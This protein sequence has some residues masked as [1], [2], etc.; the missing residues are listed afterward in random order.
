MELNLKRPLAFFDIESTGLNVSKDRIVELC[1]IKVNPN[2]TTETKTWLLNPGYPIS[3]E[4][5]KVHGISAEDVKDKPTFK[6]VAKDI[7][8]FL[9]NCDL[10]GYNSNRF[11][12]PMLVEEFLRAGVDFD[13]ENR[14]FIDVQ[15]IFMK[16]EPRTLKAAYRFY[17]QKE[18]ENA[19]SATAD[20]QATYE[21]L[22]AQ[23][24]RYAHTAYTDKEG[25][26][27]T[28]VKNDVDA[29]AKFST[30]HRN[31]DLMGQIIYNEKGEEVFNFGKHKGK[32]VEE[33][34]RQEPSYYDWMQK[35]DFPLYTKK[36]L[37]KIK[38]RM[39]GK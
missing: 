33:V 6:Q 27:G 10:A 36:L 18:L 30:H 11:D 1:I 22:K 31:A 13:V 2:G 3:E 26:T 37:T 4:A 24:D 32:T 21:V 23:L 19:H 20:V 8:R 38:L 9:A 15:N 34:F 7:H 16:M 14:R 28:P 35:A 25:E 12:I 29:L 39:L 17:L 5:Q